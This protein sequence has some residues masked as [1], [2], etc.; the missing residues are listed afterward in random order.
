MTREEEQN[1]QFYRTDSVQRVLKRYDFSDNEKQIIHEAIITA[2]RDVPNM[3]AIAKADALLK[4]IAS[5]R[6]PIS[7]EEPVDNMAEK[8]MLSQVNLANYDQPETNFWK[9]PIDSSTIVVIGVFI[10]ICLVLIIN[11]FVVKGA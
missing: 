9:K 7:M 1:V 2:K 6:E 4:M 10:W 3:K 11:H 5:S 8:K